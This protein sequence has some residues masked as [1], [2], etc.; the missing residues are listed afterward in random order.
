VR[1]LRLILLWAGAA[2]WAAGGAAIVVFLMV[3]L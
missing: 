3:P 2:I 1:R